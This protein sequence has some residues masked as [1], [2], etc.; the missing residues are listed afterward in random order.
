LFLLL[1]TR[2][3]EE[4]E[5]KAKNTSV[6]IM[7]GSILVGQALIVKQVIFPIMSVI[8]L[9]VLGREK[10]AGELFKMLGFAA[11]YIILAGVLAILCILFSFWM[12]RVLTPR[13]NQLEEIKKN[14]VAVAILM[15][16]VIIGICLL[17]SSG[18]SGLTRAL[19]PFP[20]VGS[21]PLT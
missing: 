19:I 5:L 3:D 21:V 8:Q 13:I 10:T 1:T 14:N 12:F 11:G 16:L 4:Q 7:L 17:V 15:G 2:I 20:E 9:F 6:G 18:V